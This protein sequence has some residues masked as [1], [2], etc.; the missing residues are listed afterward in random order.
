MLI[1]MLIAVQPGASA[2]PLHFCG[3]MF[4]VGHLAH[5]FCFG[6]LTHSMPLRIGGIV[7]ILTS[8]GSLA[9]AQLLA[10]L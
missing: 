1:L 3:A 10:L 6:L 4:V 9:I 8:L 2:T 5:C 7:L